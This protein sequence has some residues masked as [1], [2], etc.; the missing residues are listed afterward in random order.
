MSNHALIDGD[1]LMGPV[2]TQP[3]VPVLIHGEG[4]PGSPTQ[5]VG[6][7]R[8]LLDHH[9]SLDPGKPAKLF[10]DN[11]RLELPLYG[12][13]HML[14][15]TPSANTCVLTGRR[16]AVGR[17]FDHLLNIGAQVSSAGT[18]RSDLG[19]D[20]FAGQRMADEDDL[21]VQSGDKVPAMRNGSNRQLDEVADLSPAQES[22]SS[23][24]VRSAVSGV[25]SPRRTAPGPKLSGCSSMPWLE[26]N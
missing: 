12:E 20:H 23:A 2:G 19:H 8:Q 24:T 10:C 6:T 21:P 17:C 13:C 22:I 11:L 25:G 18:D 14:E 7:L 26:R 15:V 1:H 3:N 4:H 16:H 9:V 5:S